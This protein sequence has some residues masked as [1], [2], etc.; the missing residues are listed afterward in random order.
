[1][2]KVVVRVRRF[3]L[4]SFQHRA[5]EFLRARGDA[6]ARMQSGAGGYPCYSVHANLASSILKLTDRTVSGESAS[7]RGAFLRPFCATLTYGY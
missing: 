6:E 7:V 4:D 1:M 3:F 2:S 5:P